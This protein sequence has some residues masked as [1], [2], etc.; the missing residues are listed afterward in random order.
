MFVKKT[1]MPNPIKT[2]DISSTAARVATNLLKPI[3]ILSNTTVRRSEVD[4]EDLK[5]YWKS[6]KG[7]IFLGDQQ[8]YYF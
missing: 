6:K 7:H 1:S 2:L 5:P 3:A 8:S 4:Q